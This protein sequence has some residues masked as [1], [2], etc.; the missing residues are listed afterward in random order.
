MEACFLSF[1]ASSEVWREQVRPASEERCAASRRNH[2]CWLAVKELNLSCYNPETISIYIYIHI[3]VT[4]Y[5]YIYIPFEAAMWSK[6]PDL[7]QKP[8]PCAPANSTYGVL[9]GGGSKGEGYLRHLGEPR[10]A[11]GNTREYWGVLSY[12]TPWTPLP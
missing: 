2:Q 4:L 8:R 6:G 1:G 9:K 12:L 3:V 7:R 5:I 11:L 10:G